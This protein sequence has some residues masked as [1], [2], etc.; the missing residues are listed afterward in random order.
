M[1]RANSRS[2]S[3]R[4]TERTSGAQALEVVRLLRRTSICAWIGYYRRY[5]L[6]GGLHDERRE[7][8]DR[9]A[10]SREPPGQAGVRNADHRPPGGG[11]AL[12]LQVP[13]P[14][15]HGREQREDP[16]PGDDRGR[17]DDAADGV[18]LPRLRGPVRVHAQ[19]MG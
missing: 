14:R 6:R 12:L 3:E 8:P 19:W 2:A 11:P 5:E 10:G 7:H 13:R 16:R 1:P 17:G 18:A 9:T 15:R 4:L